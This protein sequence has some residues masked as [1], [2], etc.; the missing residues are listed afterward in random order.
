MQVNSWQGT[1]LVALLLCL[2]CSGV[3]SFTAD[4]LRDLQQENTKLD[5]KKNLLLSA[6]LIA[7]KNVPRSEIE[8]I[9]ENVE[10]KVVN[11][12]TGEY[13]D[14]APDDFDAR[15]AAKDASQNIE[16]PA[17]KDIAKNRY[18]AKWGTVYLI[19]E[20]GKLKELHAIANTL[21][22]FLLPQCATSI[23]VLPG[24]TPSHAV[25]ALQLIQKLK[26]LR[27]CKLSVFLLRQIVLRHLLNASPAAFPVHL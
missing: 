22:D 1:I 14:D 15:A 23:K 25:K 12:E 11:L 24:D 6:G 16:I 2:V 27:C 18:R 19:K 10:T 21:G 8:E 20:S 26:S 17:E 5:V 3:V 7:G 9:F 13:V 4:N